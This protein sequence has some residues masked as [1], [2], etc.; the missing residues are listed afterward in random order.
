[1]PLRLSRS[2]TARAPSD[3]SEAPALPASQPRAPSPALNRFE[4]K[5]L[6]PSA[7]QEGDKTDCGRWLSAK[8]WHWHR[9]RAPAVWPALALGGVEPLLT[10]PKAWLE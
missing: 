8:C 2:H 10:L 5:P 6:T 7:T 3:T 4:E 9:Q 1:M